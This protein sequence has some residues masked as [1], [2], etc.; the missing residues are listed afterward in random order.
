MVLIEDGDISLHDAGDLRGLTTW[1]VTDALTRRHGTGASVASIGPAGENLARQ[2]ST[3]VD[4]YASAARGSG[5]VWGSKRLKVVVVRGTGRPELFDR[6]GFIALAH[7]DKRFLTQDRVQRG[8]AAAYGSHCG[9]TH[10]FPG[11]RN[12]AKL[13][14]GEEIPPGLRP[15]ALKAYEI[16]RSGCRTCHIKCRNQFRIPQGGRNGERG[17]GLEYEAIYCLGTNCGV[18][19][20]I[21]IMEMESLCDAYGVDVIELGNT[22][23]LAKDLYHRGVIDDGVTD[24]LDLSGENAA[25]QAFTANASPRWPIASA[26]ARWP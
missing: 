2:A 4:K 12:S 3:M 26:A 8:V 10:W 6:A 18:L 25:D 24:G 15:E 1:A 11:F 20:P 7:E 23:A 5:A 13:L 19:D 22:I 14:A 9:V 17:A 16:G 21:A